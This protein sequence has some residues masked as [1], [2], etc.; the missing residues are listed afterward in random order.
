MKKPTEEDIERCMSEAFSMVQKDVNWW[1]ENRAGKPG[2]SI[3]YPEV[4]YDP[5]EFSHREWCI[6]TIWNLVHCGFEIDVRVLMY[7]TQHTGSNKINSD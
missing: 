5:V 2:A 7:V 1:N 4:T 3:L 6:T